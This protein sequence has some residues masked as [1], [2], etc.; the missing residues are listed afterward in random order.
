MLSDEF[1]PKRQLQKLAGKDV[2]AP[3]YSAAQP[4]VIPT[5]DHSPTQNMVPE[6]LL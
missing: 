3:T 4:L 5:I 6:R 2:S 1:T